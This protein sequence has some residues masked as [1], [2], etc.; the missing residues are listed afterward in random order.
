AN[1]SLQSLD[2]CDNDLRSSSLNDFELVDPDSNGYIEDL[3]EP[4]LP[5]ELLGR[6]TLHITSLQQLDLSANGIDGADVEALLDGGVLRGSLHSLRLSDNALLTFTAEGAEAFGEAVMRSAALRTLDLSLN[7]LQP[8]HLVG[9]VAGGL[10]RGAVSTLV[11]HNNALGGEGVLDDA[12]AG[13]EALAAGLPE[14]TCLR[15]LD[16]STTHMGPRGAVAFAS[17]PRLGRAL[18]AVDLVGNRLGPEG[19]DALLAARKRTPSL[20]TLCGLPPGAATVRPEGRPLGP[21]GAVLLASDLKTGAIG[22]SMR[23]LHIADQEIG[24]DAGS[25]DVADGFRAISGVLRGCTGLTELSL[26]LNNI[27]PRGAAALAEGLALSR[28]LTSVDLL[29]ALEDLGAEGAAVLVEAFQKSDTLATLCGLEPGVRQLDM[30]EQNLGPWGAMLLAAELRMG[31]RSGLLHTIDLQGNA[32]AGRTGSSGAECEDGLRALVAAFAVSP[33][34]ASVSLRSNGIGPKC[35]AA[36]A[37]WL[38]AGGV[39][40]PRLLDLRGNPIS[41]HDARNLRGA[42]V[43][44]SGCHLEIDFLGE[45]MQM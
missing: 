3:A 45:S 8:A 6:S 40:H 16:L 38:A 2:L 27:R 31:R 29:G 26:R 33:H 30:F 34:L 9:L 13:F 5:L 14:N 32:L 36:V 1:R 23:T 15:A 35:A 25:H 19:A 21:W 20:R 17:A 42:M 24:T 44:Q 28:S 22:D 11:L 43:E 7:D 41:R 12:V 10:L 4:L 39:S 18:A 37:Q